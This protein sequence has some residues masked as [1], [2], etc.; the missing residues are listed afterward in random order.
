[1]IGDSFFSYKY[2][3]VPFTGA[4]RRLFLH[5]LL[6]LT[7]DTFGIFVHEPRLT[8]RDLS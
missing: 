4:S 1:M 2:L 6:R 7:R 3:L 5:Y 8:S